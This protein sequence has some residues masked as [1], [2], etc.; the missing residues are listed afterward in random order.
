[1][2]SQRLVLALFLLCFATGAHA[3]YARDEKPVPLTTQLDNA[4]RRTWHPD[5]PGATVLVARDGQ[6]ILRKAYGFANIEH[7][8]ELE[9]NM[10][11]RL[12]SITKQFTAALVMQDVEAGRISL[13][14]SVD[15]H[16]PGWPMHGQAIT[17]RHLLNHTSGIHGYTS[18]PGYFER[19]IRAD[20]SMDEL[21]AV[22]RDLPMDFAPGEAWACNN[23]AYVMLG[24]ILE[25]VNG[26]SYAE[27][28]RERIAEPLGLRSLR[29]D[30]QAELIPRRVSGYQGERNA[31]RNADVLSMSQ[32]HAAGSLMANVDDLQRWTIALHE[33]R[34]VS[35]ESL[36]EMTRVTRV[37]GEVVPY[38]YGLQLGEVRGR[39]SVSHDGGINGFATSA[40][41]LPRQ[42]L[43]VTVLSNDPD[44]PIGPRFLGEKLAGIA[45]GDPHPSFEAMRADPKDLATYAGTYRLPDGSSRVVSAEKGK[46]YTQ[47]GQGPKLEAKAYGRH[48]FFYPGR[49][50]HFEF[51]TSSAGTITGMLMYQ[52]GRDEP[53][54][55]ERER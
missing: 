30:T 7:G 9:P 55:A 1:M 39:P 11:L 47:R 28:V 14:D 8:I 45:L 23:S 33:G 12:G 40:L 38:G 50:S 32:L 10:P 44:N 48:R 22:F 37:Q 42:K 15:E 34:V 13:D 24:A 27:L 29:Y 49:F 4:V 20:L 6:T 19:K 17:V 26:S 46:L 35:R 3:R 43:F 5:G 54:R 31:W 21:L 2:R 36:N 18:I 41:Y 16:L 25:T 51:T 52:D 53:E